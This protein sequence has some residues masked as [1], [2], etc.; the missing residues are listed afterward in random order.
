M[1][2]PICAARKGSI[3]TACWARSV[4]HLKVTPRRAAIESACRI[5][6]STASVRAPSEAWRISSM[7]RASPAITFVAPGLASRNPTVDTIPGVRCA[8]FS[9][10]R[11]H[12]A[13]AASASCL[14]FMGVVPAWFACPENVNSTR[15]W[16]TI[17]ST[18]PSGR[19]KC[20]S[21][22]PCSM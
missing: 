14:R 18:T 20:S 4:R 9:T 11:I 21:T 19:P 8:K 7:A 5:N 22:G 10:A 13:A 3:A 12:S 6:S 16:P 15:L 2:C 1:A 17:A